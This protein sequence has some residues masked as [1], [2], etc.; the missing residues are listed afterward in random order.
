MMERA[1]TPICR[2]R[3]RPE[4]VTAESGVGKFLRA[5]RCAKEALT[6]G[7]E[8]RRADPWIGPSATAGFIEA[9]GSYFFVVVVVVVDGVVFEATLRL[10]L[11]S[12][13][14]LS[15][16]AFACFLHALLSAPFMSS[17]F[18]FATS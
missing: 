7:R 5:R 8:M 14:A 10:A 13:I 4:G 9:A 16:S 12:A 18:S 6:S 11:A 15:L 3:G 2:R 1:P 17:H